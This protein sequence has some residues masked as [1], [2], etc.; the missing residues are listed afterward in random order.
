M[1]PYIAL[2]PMTEFDPRELGRRLHE[3]V[4]APENRRLFID[5]PALKKTYGSPEAAAE[6]VKNRQNDM[7]QL[8]V[9]AKTLK[10]MRR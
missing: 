6:A 4:A 3:I 7:R 1:T 9:S 2:R 10:E 8:F 5:F